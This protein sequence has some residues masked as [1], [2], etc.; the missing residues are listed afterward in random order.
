MTISTASSSPYCSILAR[1]SSASTSP[2]SPVLTTTTFM[3]A[4]TALAALV[5]CAEDGMRQTVRWASPLARWYARTAS[6][7][8]SS[9]CEPAFGWS[10]TLS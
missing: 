1:R 2:S 6:S 10:D 8:A 9:P 7:P 3:P 5:P 4:M